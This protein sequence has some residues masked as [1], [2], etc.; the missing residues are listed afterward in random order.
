M[1]TIAMDCLFLIVK[2]R[3]VFFTKKIDSYPFFYDKLIECIWIPDTQILALNI[4]DHLSAEDSRQI[5][6]TL[7]IR[8]DI[9][10]QLH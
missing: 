4:I 7:L 2:H 10:T 9:V 5:A 1:L 3:E 8:C 6:E